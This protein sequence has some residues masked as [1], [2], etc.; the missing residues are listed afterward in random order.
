MTEPADLKVE[1]VEA[2][3]RFEAA[4]QGQTAFLEYHLGSNFISLRHTE[5]PANLEGHGIGGRL[6]QAALEFAR[7]AN[8]KV[9]PL[10]PFVVAYLR[11]HPEY[12]DLVEEKYRSRVAS[13]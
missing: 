9:V 12:L 4:V 3:H 8:R 6:A 13:H 5:V 7:G 2:A 10:C 1:H 11:R